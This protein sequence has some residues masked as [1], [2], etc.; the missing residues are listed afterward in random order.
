MNLVLITEINFWTRIR[1]HN[2]R[3]SRYDL[4][5]AELVSYWP[6]R[7]NNVADVVNPATSLH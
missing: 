7:D 1:S 4:I 5:D 6:L 2:I 3:L